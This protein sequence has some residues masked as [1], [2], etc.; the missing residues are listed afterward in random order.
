MREKWKV[1]VIGA[2]KIPI[3]NQIILVALKLLKLI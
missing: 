1:A 2:E 3:F